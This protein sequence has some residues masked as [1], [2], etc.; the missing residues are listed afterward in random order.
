ML[1]ALVSFF[2]SV[3]TTSKNNEHFFVST[4][5]F[6]MAYSERTPLSSGSNDHGISIPSGLKN[7]LDHLLRRENLQQA[8]TVAASRVDD[9]RKSASDGD[10]SLRLLALAGGAFLIVSALLGMISHLVFL[11][12]TSVLVEFYTL[13]MGVVMVVLESRQ[14]MLPEWFLQL[15]YKY[16]LF[17]KFIWGRGCLYFVA[18][19]LQMSQGSFT[20]VIV[21]FCVCL[22]GV[23][24]I[25]IG[26]RAAQ[27]LQNA[28]SLLTSEHTVRSKFRE[29]NIRGHNAL[30]IQEFRLLMQSLGLHISRREAEAAFLQVNPEDSGELTYD[31]FKAWWE[32]SL[33]SSRVSAMPMNA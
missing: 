3:S 4:M 8:Q 33:P 20:D 15:L 10:V 6:T 30:D 23:A 32:R 29:A 1:S 28:R 26:H 17:L 9:L 31:D 22:L 24:F 25:V 13:V 21:G 18:G 19:T 27:K 12:F 2:E 11:Q 16:A 14:V 7:A 5:I